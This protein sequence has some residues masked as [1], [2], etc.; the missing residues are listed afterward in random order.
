MDTNTI[1]PDCYHQDDI[2]GQN[3]LHGDCSSDTTNPAHEVMNQGGRYVSHAEGGTSA[4]QLQSNQVFANWEVE[5]EDWIR[6]SNLAASLADS[7]EN[8]CMTY[9][10]VT[11]VNLVSGVDNANL[12]GR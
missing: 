11:S 3:N 1:E 4:I 5:M 9:S 6:N 8:N 7:G 2:F 10:T 12:R